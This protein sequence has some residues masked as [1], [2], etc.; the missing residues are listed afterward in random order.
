MM[1]RVVPMVLLLAATMPIP[2]IAFAPG[3]SSATVSGTIARGDADSWSLTA[4]AGQTADMRITSVENNASF[5]I[6]MPGAVA[7]P[8]SDGSG[9][10]IKGR[11]LPG[12]DPEKPALDAGAQ[13]H[14]RGTLPATGTYLISVAPDRGGASYK[15]AVRIQ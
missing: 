6:F 15:L 7:T 4:R 14:W 8:A 12:G 9:D 10:D 13:K 3:R 11:T 5:V 1:L 2:E